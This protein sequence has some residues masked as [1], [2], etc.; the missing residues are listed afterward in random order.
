MW[1]QGRCFWFSVSLACLK[2]RMCHV[3]VAQIQRKKK[4]KKLQC[5][6]FKRKQT[7]ELPDQGQ[8]VL[9]VWQVERLVDAVLQDGFRSWAGSSSGAAAGSQQSCAQR[10][11]RCLQ[12]LQ[13]DGAVSGSAHSSSCVTIWKSACLCSGSGP[14][15]RDCWLPSSVLHF[16]LGIVPGFP[17]EEAHLERQKAL[18]FSF[19]Q[20][21]SS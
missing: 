10:P 14:Q 15:S 11:A 8:R 20:K 9:N 18:L 1:E 13:G 7:R 12:G 6:F 2:I 4:P 16:L 17:L 3:K 21:R 5:F 19:L